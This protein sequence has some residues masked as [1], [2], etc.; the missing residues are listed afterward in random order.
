MDNFSIDIRN[1]GNILRALE[2]AFEHCPGKTAVAYLV[3]NNAR[4]GDG[5]SILSRLLFFW[6]K[7][8]VATDLP[9]KLDVVGAADFAQRW[10]AEQN[11]G[12]EPDH[13]G[14]NGR[15]WRVYNKSL[16]RATGHAYSFVAIEPCWAEY[17]K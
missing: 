9:F 8:K 3:E 4:P 6:N 13:D 15:G 16:G 1:D 14:D 5:G 2:I 11:Y 7:D 12:N 17:G 10:L